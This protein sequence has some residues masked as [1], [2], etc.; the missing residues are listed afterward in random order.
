MQKVVFS[1]FGLVRERE[2]RQMV[3]RHIERIFYRPLVAWEERKRGRWVE[4]GKGVF[5]DSRVWVRTK[6]MCEIEIVNW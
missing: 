5:W 4:Y 3:G 1:L 2:G 6:K